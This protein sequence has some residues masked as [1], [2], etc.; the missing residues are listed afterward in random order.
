MTAFLLRNVTWLVP[1]SFSA[2][3]LAGFAWWLRR[4]PRRRITS[5]TN[6]LD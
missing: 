4:T 3:A 2:A 6:W 1:L 5:R